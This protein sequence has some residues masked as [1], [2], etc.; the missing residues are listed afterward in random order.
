[1]VLYEYFKLLTSFQM[2]FILLVIIVPINSFCDQN[3][4]FKND[5]E[6]YLTVNR[7]Q[8]R[9]RRN[10]AEISWD[11]FQMLIDPTCHDI[12]SARLE[13]KINGV[14]SWM[15]SKENMTFVGRKRKWTVEIKPCFR[16]YF[17]IKF[18]PKGQEQESGHSYSTTPETSLEP[19]ALEEISRS[20][21]TPD[22]PSSIS[23]NV[24]SHN[25]ILSWKPSDCV[26][27]YEVIYFEAGD[28]ENLG[29]KTIKNE[30]TIVITD[31]KPCTNYK[32]SIY[33][34]FN[35]NYG[36]LVS[37][38]ATLPVKDIITDLEVDVK[39][40]QHEIEL[41][42]PTWKSVSCIDQYEIEVHVA[43]NFCLVKKE[44]VQKNVGSPSMVYNIL[45]LTSNETYVIYI[46][47][48]FEKMDLLAKKI[49]L[50]TELSS[51]VVQDSNIKKK[52][53]LSKSISQVT[54]LKTSERHSDSFEKSIAITWPRTLTLQAYTF[55]VLLLNFS[56]L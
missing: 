34:I 43:N 7:S 35:D 39:V 29:I 45:G 15:T 18:P 16:Y 41:S 51:D 9:G 49:V 8:R 3:N 37:A 19:L 47:P 38:F 26:T 48:S 5:S 25:A 42:W 44:V 27:D 24:S 22:P 2:I 11:A 30:T 36:E 52:C 55:C 13:I 46:K 21:Y 28:E 31:L 4:I 50:Q 54:N 1:M 17:R 33:A 20:Q 14:T 53:I 10:K 23:V 56:Q 12:Q 40:G 6:Q 32:I